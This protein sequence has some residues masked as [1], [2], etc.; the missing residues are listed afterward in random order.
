MSEELAAN[1]V[2][3]PLIEVPGSAHAGYAEVGIGPGQETVWELTIRFVRAQ[4]G[5][6][7]RDDQTIPGTDSGP[8][9]LPLV[10][11]AVAAALVVFVLVLRRTLRG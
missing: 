3:S 9:V 1:G 10:L 6:S 8:W 5:E 7:V 2:P 11:A 4:L